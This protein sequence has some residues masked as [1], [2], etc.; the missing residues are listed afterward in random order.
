[1]QTAPPKRGS[2]C[3]KFVAFLAYYVRICKLPVN[4]FIMKK[5]QNN[6]QPQ[7]F[8]KWTRFFIDRYRISILLIIAI[9]IAGVMGVSDIPKQD[10]PDIPTNLVLVTAVYPGASSSD[11]EQD[12]IIPLENELSGMDDIE[13]IRSSTANSFGSIFIEFSDFQNLD[14]KVAKAGD[15]AKE[16]NLP[17][18]AE[19]NADQIDVMGP[20]VAYAMTSADKSLTELLEL[21]PEAA[22]YLESSSDEI[23]EVM[24]MPEAEMEIDIVLN[25]AK[26]ARYQLTKD[27]VVEAVKSFTTTLPGGFVTTDE[28]LEK[29]IAV[30]SPIIGLEDLENLKIGPV[31]LK[32]I[33]EVKRVPANKEAYTIAGYING[34]GEA[35][36]SEAVYL[37]AYKKSDGDVLRV[38]D[39]LSGAVAGIHDQGVVPDDVELEKAFDTSPYVRSLIRDLAENG[40]I[41]LIVILVVLL[42][43]VNLRAGLVVA[44]IIPLA[45]LITWFVL[46]LFGYTLNILTLFSMILA[47]GILVDNAIVIAEGIMANLERGMKKRA[48]AFKAVKDF[49][50]AIATATVTTIIVLVPYALIGGIMGEFFKIIPITLIVMLLGSFFL[51]ISITP[52]FGKWLLRETTIEEK[53]SRKLKSWQ[54]YL[55][56]P[57]LVFYAQRFI[58]WVVRGYQCMMKTVLG[59][60][61][62]IAL[63]VVAALAFMGFSFGY[64]LPQL[65]FTQFPENDGEQ[66]SVSVDFPAG[67]SYDDKKEVYDKIGEE[68]LTIPYFESFFFYEGQ[69]MIF[70]TEPAERGDETTSND[71]AAD[72]DSK[73]EDIRTDDIL[74]VAQPQSYGPPAEEFDVIVEFSSADGDKIAGAVD[75]LESFVQDKENIDRIQNGP[76][77]LLIPAVEVKF[78]EDKLAAVSGSPLMSSVMI[79]SM[80]TETESGKVVVR[81]DGVSD[82]VMVLFDEDAQDSISDL[83]DTLVV[84][85]EGGRPFRLGDVAEVVEVDRLDTISRLDGQRVGAFRVKM[86]DEGDAA[87]LEQEIKD[88]LTNEKLDEL[89]L[90][91]DD[92]IYGGEFASVMETSSDLQ[93]VFVIAIILVYIVLVY[94]FNSFGQPIYILFTVPLA[95]IGVFPGLFW[96]GSTLDMVS[97]LGVIALVGIVVNDAIVFVDYFNRV[98]RENPEI[99]LAQALVETGKARFKPIFT[100]SITTIGG[101]LPLTINEPFWTG[102]G[103]SVVSGLIFST[104]GTLIVVPTIIYIFS[105]RKNKDKPWLDVSNGAD[106]ANGCKTK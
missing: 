13:T 78:D 79:N 82:E 35:K 72:L 29:P 37:M 52:L 88:Y 85:P 86:T 38:S 69:F 75:D 3:E 45:F 94:Q 56:F 76:E 43:F 101:I 42:L 22:S 33:A 59:K 36:S 104:I 39:A 63:V 100:T 34:D 15:L 49:G 57:A 53:R 14:E 44:L 67:T 61:K 74:I 92:V 5:E 12:V 62:W 102:L 51:A 97:G 31:A 103:T 71:I 18:D 93:V 106:I 41:G 83:E 84:S 91:S 54:K 99:P 28:G 30:N 32:E 23:K 73:L 17:E 98:R 20:T 16:A 66:L 48:A 55:V 64:F 40:I 95:L 70:I 68:I 47:L 96:T 11:V 58:D 89:G 87:I 77:E 50:P 6:S 80:F 7:G 1:L 21:A 25:S 46:P 8:A 81:E 65:E 19:V 24:I 27:I 10:F 9:I 60:K 4:I 105:R 2:F 26:A 90:E